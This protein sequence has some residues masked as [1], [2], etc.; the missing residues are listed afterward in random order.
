MQIEL[1]VEEESAEAALRILLP[2]LLRSEFRTR[3]GYFKENRIC[4]Q[5]CLSGS[6]GMRG[7][8]L[9]KT[10]GSSC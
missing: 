8:S 4:S 5:S 3:S 6:R 2:K 7:E 10:C 1:L 9:E